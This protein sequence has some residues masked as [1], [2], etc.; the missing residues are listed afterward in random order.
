MG[1][2]QLKSGIKSQE[3]V[4]ERGKKMTL[5]VNIGDTESYAAWME[6]ANTLEGFTENLSDAEAMRRLKPM[7]KE[8][9]QMIFGRFAWF[10]VYRFCRGNIFAV[11]KIIETFSDI[12]KDG[13]MENVGK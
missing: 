12:I 13:V 5:S 4:N 11:M 6:K 7:A 9:V 8:L 2:V 10:R 3:F 1:A